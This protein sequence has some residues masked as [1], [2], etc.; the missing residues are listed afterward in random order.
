M[1]TERW[2]GLVPRLSWRSFGEGGPAVVDVPAHMEDFD[3]VRG[4]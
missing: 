1:G 2:T 4:Q 3:I